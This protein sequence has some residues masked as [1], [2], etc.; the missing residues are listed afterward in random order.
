MS[1][2]SGQIFNLDKTGVPL[3]PKPPKIITE[4]G[5]KHPICITGHD[6]GQITVLSCCSAGGYAI[7]PLVIFYKKTLKPELTVGEVEYGLSNKGWI[8]TELLESWFTKHFLA[9]ASPSR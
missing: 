2:R 8:D 6:K 4:K 7:P 3:N 1:D 5:E 9:Y